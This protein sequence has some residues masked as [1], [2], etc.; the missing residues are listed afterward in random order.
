MSSLIKKDFVSQVLKAQKKGLPLKI[1]KYSEL[2]EHVNCK[3]EDIIEWYVALTECVSLLSIEHEKLIEKLL[4]FDWSS[5]EEVIQ[6]YSNFLLHLVSAH[7]SF[8]APTFRMFAQNFFPKLKSEEP[9]SYDLEISIL[10]SQRIHFCLKNILS[11][12]P[13]SPTRLAH[14][15][16]SKYPHI[17]YDS[18]VHRHYL[19]NLLNILDY[20]PILQESIFDIVIGKLLELDVSI[21]IDDLP[22]EEEE[23]IFELDGNP[24]VEIAEKM[25]F[26]MDLVFNYIYAHKEDL[27]QILKILLKNFEIRLLKTHKAKFTQFLIFYTCNFCQT[28]PSHFVDLLFSKLKDNREHVTNRIVCAA[29][30]GGF[31]SRAKF[32]SFQLVKKT[33][34]EMSSWALNYLG[35]LTRNQPDA[36]IHALFYAV[37]QSILYIICFHFQ[38]LIE[39]QQFL[40]TLKLDTLISCSLNPLKFCLPAIVKE[41]SNFAQFMDVKSFFPIYEQNKLLIIPTQTSKGK[42]NQLEQYFPFDPYLLHH[43]SPKIRDIY[44]EWTPKKCEEEEDEGAMDDV[45]TSNTPAS[46]GGFLTPTE[47][48]MDYQYQSSLEISY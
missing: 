1:S 25:D 38:T 29:Y 12:V 4:E 33:L 43:S 22:E 31:V 17:R 6:S 44:V 24:N 46:M 15:L 5:E 11:L 30:I 19:K 7:N 10:I 16:K 20:C 41:F 2:I 36:E 28:Y 34:V 42:N 35:N 9:P 47:T 23:L 48:G 32:T 39:S 26:L 45:S 18:H 37:C 40:K 3:N 13:S 14:E 21:Q 8:I 27:D